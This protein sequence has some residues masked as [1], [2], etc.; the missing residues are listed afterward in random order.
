MPVGGLVG[1]VELLASEMMSPMTDEWSCS[2]FSIA[3]PR[4]DRASD[5]P[6]LPVAARSWYLYSHRSWAPGPSPRGWALLCAGPSVTR[7]LGS[8]QVPS[9][10][11]IRASRSGP[12]TTAISDGANQKL[13]PD[14]SNRQRNPHI[15]WPQKQH[16]DDHQHQQ[17]PEYFRG[18]LAFR[19]PELR[20]V[21]IAGR[22]P[23][24][25]LSAPACHASTVAARTTPA[26]TPT[27]HLRASE[28]GVY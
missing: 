16:P 25:R 5:L 14:R 9:T 2:Q 3:N 22:S 4:D 28:P 7:C 20:T 21:G 27:G 15:A 10:S 11:L 23:L 18:R 12:G 19:L 24:P 17:H 13:N 1:C 6:E 26:R 8:L